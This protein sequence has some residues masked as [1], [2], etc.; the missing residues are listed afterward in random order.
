MGVDRDRHRSSGPSRP[1]KK[2]MAAADPAQL[3]PT[4]AARWLADLGFLASSDLPDRPGPAFL[5]VALRELPTLRHYDPE[6]VDYW[7][8]AAGRGARRTLTRET[9]MPLTIEFS[10]GLI[11]ITDRLKVTNEYLTLGGSL[12]AEPWGTQS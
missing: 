9:R 12:R 6:L 1:R 3:D 10:W 4:T 8:T 11:R 2:R 5:L 7:V